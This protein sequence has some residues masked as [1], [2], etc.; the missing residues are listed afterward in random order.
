MGKIKQLFSAQDMTEGRPW[1]LILNFTLPLILGNFAQQLYN[2]VDSMV[3]GQYIGDNALSA[4]GVSIP[5][6]FVLTVLFIG[7]STGASIMVS[8]YFG[9]KKRDELGY[10]IGNCLSLTV[11]VSLVTMSV[12]FVL[13]WL[14]KILKTP[15]ILYKDAL[16]YLKIV[17]LGIPAIAYYNILSGILRGLG[18]SASALFYL[19]L[20]T[21]INILLDLTFVKYLHWGIAGVAIATVIAQRISAVLCFLKLKHMKEAFSLEKRHYRLKK[22]IARDMISL[23]LPSGATQAIFSLAGLLVQSLVNDYGEFFVAASFIVMRVDGFAMLPNFSFGIAMTTYTGQNVGAG[24]M[25][26]VYAGIKEGL[27]VAL[28]ISVMMTALILIFGKQLMSLFSNTEAL[29]NYARKLMFILAPGYL[30][31]SITQSLSGTMRGAGDTVTPLIIGIINTVCIRVPAAYILTY[32][33]R[34]AAYP[35]GRPEMIIFSLM[36]TWILG[37]LVNILVFQQ[38]KWEKKIIIRSGNY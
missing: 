36:L 6:L 14:L 22:A 30:A 24:R 19:I 31:F 25:E 16:I 37:A 5:I 23:G 3:V 8:Q 29:V 34:S 2:T 17:L 15:D 18:D 32:L 28:S 11:I 21:V 10:T 1:R 13:P 20:S 12:Y 9:A 35:K 4:V 38:R 26:R 33:T 7:L 27:I